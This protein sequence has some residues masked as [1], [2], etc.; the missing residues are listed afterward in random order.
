MY[1]ILLT[2]T[3]ADTRITANSVNFSQS[4]YRTMYFL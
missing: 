4:L 2:G 1:Q 3:L